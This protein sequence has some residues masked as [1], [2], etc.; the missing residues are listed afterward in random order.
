VINHLIWCLTFGI[1][2]W[3]FCE[4]C[5]A[6]IVLLFAE[7]PLPIDEG[8]T[9]TKTMRGVVLLGP[10]GLCLVLKRIWYSDLR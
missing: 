3:L 9:L 2:F 5:S 1:V 6:L 8:H 10:I 7:R 4:V